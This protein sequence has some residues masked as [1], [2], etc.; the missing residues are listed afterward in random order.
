MPAPLFARFV[1]LKIVVR[2]IYYTLNCLFTSNFQ[3]C[4]DRNVNDL[5]N[6]VWFKIKLIMISDCLI[7][8]ILI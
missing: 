3:G 6:F 4:C 5:S 2:K 8:Q 1:Y 7:N